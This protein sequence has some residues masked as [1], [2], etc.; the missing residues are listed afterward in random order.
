MSTHKHNPENSIT[1]RIIVRAFWLWTAITAVAETIFGQLG[2]EEP[3]RPDVQFEHS[4]VSARGVVLT[5]VC[6]LLGTW[7]ICA[8]I[9]LFFEHFAHQHQVESPSPL[10]VTAGASHAVPLPPEPRLQESPSRDLQEVR[11][12]AESELHKYGWVD[13]GKGTVTIP[14]EHAIDLVVQRGIPAQKTI[15]NLFYQPS[16]GS[17]LTGFEGKVEPEPR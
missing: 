2:H 15:P 5:G 16:A 12:A 3:R 1:G 14:I 17:P 4:D 11:T 6:I 9:Y 7:I 10:P 8:S 13:R